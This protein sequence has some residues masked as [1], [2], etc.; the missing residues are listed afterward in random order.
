MKTEQ[1]DNF[2]YG[3]MTILAEEI[4]RQAYTNLK[5]VYDSHRD[6]YL[7]TL[8][9]S[10]DDGSYYGELKHTHGTFG[11]Y[12]I[13]LNTATDFIDFVPVDYYEG[14]LMLSQTVHCHFTLH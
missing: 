14:N 1:H 10:A 8:Y 5:E 13:I 9:Y 12:K 11:Y 6:V 7:S 4:E 2:V 3:A